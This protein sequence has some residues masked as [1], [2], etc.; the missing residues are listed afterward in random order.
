M[1]VAEAITEASRPKLAS[2]VRVQF[3]KTRERWVL[4]GPE[5]VLVLDETGKEILDRATGAVTVDQIVTQLAT[6]FDASADVIRHDVLAVLRL[7]AEKNFLEI[8][9]DRT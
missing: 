6:E 4:Q 9:D 2:F 5:R 3:D 8:V 1:T 7:L